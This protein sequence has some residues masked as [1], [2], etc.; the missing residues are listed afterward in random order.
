VLRLK[1]LQ[2]LV[3]FG[4]RIPLHAA[5]VVASLGA[6]IAWH[7]SGRLRGITRDH[8]RH[9]LPAST[10][11]RAIDRAAQGAVRSAAYY[12]VDFARYAHLDPEHAFDQVDSIEGL[13]Q[14]YEAY[15][16]G[17]G[18]ILA[19]AHIGNPEFIAQALAPLFDAVVLTEP[20]E[21]PAL[22]DFIHEIRARSGVSFV[23][24]DRSG[25]KTALR[26]LRC[27]GVLGL[28]LDRDVLGTGE[29]FPFFGERAPMPAGGVELVWM[30]GAALVFGT[31]IRSAPG[32]YRVTLREV[33]APV[34]ANG[35]GDRNADIESG[36]R[37]SVQAIEEAI[38]LAPDQWF[39]LSPVW[40]EPLA[41]SA[42]LSASDQSEH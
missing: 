13:D 28:L 14:L 22:H 17:H 39:A 24:A 40:T 11:R 42:E 29:S 34:R 5:Y 35:L 26:H 33:P 4:D 37:R 12:Y 38:R 8:M 27:G 36:M 1:L 16:R 20:L 9:V 21:P 30:T 25:L 41:A 19:S 3:R 32:R 2:L 7:A 10:S 15:D 23:A 6:S 18:V 31:V